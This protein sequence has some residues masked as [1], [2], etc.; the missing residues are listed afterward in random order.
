MLKEQYV[1]QFG[2]FK[3]FSVLI[4]GNT[5]T[6]FSNFNCRDDE[7]KN[8][9]QN[10]VVYSRDHRRILKVILCP[11]NFSRFDDNVAVETMN[12]ED[13]FLLKSMVD[14]L[15]R[16]SWLY[17]FSNVK[18]FSHFDSQ[19]IPVEW[20][21]F[22][23]SCST[24]TLKDILLCKEDSEGLF[25]FVYEFVKERNDLVAKFEEHI[26]KSN[27]ACH[28]SFPTRGMSL[29]K[30]H[31]V[32][33]FCN[34]LSTH[35]N[36]ENESKKTDPNDTREKLQHTDLIVDCGSGAGHLERGLVLGHGIGEYSTW[37]N[38]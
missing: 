20:V 37:F 8:K 24:S 35:I 16:Y 5:P 31:E 25:P 4:V 17:N 14:F 34:F 33:S 38:F 6:N 9:C 12:M 23:T 11:T 30:I 19:Q 3:L 7:N 32:K 28:N 22:M 2:F 36:L 1:R 18:V 26:G 10:L 13:D 21:K 27:I 15:S 29:K